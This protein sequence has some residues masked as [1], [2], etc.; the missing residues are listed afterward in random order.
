MSIEVPPPPSSFRGFR[1]SAAGLLLIAALLA[2]CAMAPAPGDDA[3][4]GYSGAVPSQPGVLLRSEPLP[5]EFGLKAAAQQWRILYTSTDGRTGSG[6]LVTSGAV[7]YPPGPAPAGGWPIVAWAHGTTG[8]SDACAPSRSVRSKRDARYL[9]AW[10]HQGFAVVATDYQGLG[11]SR[12]SGPHLY[13]NTRPEAYAVLDSVRA[14]LSGMKNLSNRV[15]IVGQSQGGGAAFATAGYAPSYAPD[16]KVLGTV[17]T[18]T[19]DPAARSPS[20]FKPDEVNPTLAYL[21]YAGH[22]VHALDP[23]ITPGE[24]FQPRALPVY[25]QAATLCVGP[26]EKAVEAAGLTNANTL[27]PSGIAKATRALG[28]RLLYPTLKLEQPLFMGTGGAD[29]DV[30]TA[31]QLQL[32]RDACAAGTLVQQHVYP[33][34][35]HGE[36]VN[37]SLA[38]SIPFARRLLAGEPVPSTCAS[39][40]Q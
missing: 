2:G 9:D 3:F 37:A 5:A 22:M 36:T 4:Y 16:L 21:L 32:A 35:S 14:A 17:A 20:P 19:P 40:P 31:Q 30:S 1:F 11:T 13:L 24:V 12:I 25:D 34:L 39:G 33:G 27:I 38:N 7:F 26:L 15:I 23:S 8:L 6:E 29:R 10:L 28:R 18:G